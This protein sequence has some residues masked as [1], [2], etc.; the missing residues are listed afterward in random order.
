MAVDALGHGRAPGGNELGQR[1]TQNIRQ[2]DNRRIIKQIEQ[3]G[4][5]GGGFVGATQI[6]QDDGPFR[7]LSLIPIRLTPDQFDQPLDVGYRCF[8]QNAVS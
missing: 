7:H 5:N 4:L 6:K 8:R 3:K 2:I 1:P